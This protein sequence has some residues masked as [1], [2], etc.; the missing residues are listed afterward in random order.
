MQRAGLGLSLLYEVHRASHEQVLNY[1]NLRISH[2]HSSYGRSDRLLIHRPLL[3]IIRR[4]QS[5]LRDTQHIAK[6]VRLLQS[7]RLGN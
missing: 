4:F 5:R 1:P 7:K 2:N 6:A 3:S